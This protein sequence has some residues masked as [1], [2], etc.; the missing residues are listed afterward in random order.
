[1]QLSQYLL[2]WLSLARLSLAALRRCTKSALQQFQRLCHGKGDH[3]RRECFN[4]PWRSDQPLARS[5]VGCKTLHPVVSIQDPYSHI[6]GYALIKFRTLRDAYW[7]SFSLNGIGF[8]LVLFF[9]HPQNQYILEEE[10][11]RWGQVKSLD[12]VGLF[13]FTGGLV[14]FLMGI[15]FGGVT[16]PWYESR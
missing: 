1:L 9:Y 13:T 11:T 7:I 3:W 4:P 6:A 14:L 12:Y 16:Y 10:K 2:G 8:L 5:L 15:S